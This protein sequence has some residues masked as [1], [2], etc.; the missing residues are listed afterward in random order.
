MCKSMGEILGNVH[1]I[2]RDFGEREFEGQARRGKRQLKEEGA[3]V[4]KHSGPR[5]D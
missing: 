5:C 3:R 1:E 4:A 2:D